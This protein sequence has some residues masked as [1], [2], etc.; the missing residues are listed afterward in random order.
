MPLVTAVLLLAYDLVAD[1]NHVFRGGWSFESG[2]AYFGVPLQ[3]FVGWLFLGWVLAFALHRLAAVPSGTTRSEDLAVALA[4][5]VVLAHESLFALRIAALPLPAA[6]GFLEAAALVAALLVVAP[7]LRGDAARLW[8]SL[9]PDEALRG[10]VFVLAGF[11]LGQ[12]SPLAP[13]FDAAGL[14]LC[15]VAGFAGAGAVLAFNSFEGL[16]YDLFNPRHRRHPLVARELGSGQQLAVAAVAAGV[17]L[18]CFAAYRPVSAWLGLGGLAAGALYSAERL[19]SKERSGVSTLL[20]VAGAVFFV[21]A[22]AGPGIA[23]P[24]TLAAA[25]ALALLFVAGHFQHVAIDHEADR[26]AGIRTV[27]VRRGVRFATTCSIALFLAFYLLVAAFWILGWWPLELAAPFLAVAVPHFVA[28]AIIR[29][30]R[31]AVAAQGYTAT[32]RFVF[33]AGAGVAL[34]G[35]WSRSPF[36]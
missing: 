24:A 17:S 21:W 26:T 13:E 2:G 32:Y 22:G 14:W 3:N 35:W 31:S 12:P 28:F 15:L 11:L 30:W 25:A 10:A 1:P 34:V 36:P 4:Y 19:R 23:A 18:A 7:G 29:P 16:R 5:A 27:A 9:R 6:I 20:H 33:V 8:M